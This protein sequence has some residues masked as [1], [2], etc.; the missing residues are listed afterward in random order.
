LRPIASDTEE[1]N[2]NAF[3]ISFSQKPSVSKRKARLPKNRVNIDFFKATQ[4]IV[5]S[6]ESALPYPNMGFTKKSFCEE[7]RRLDLFEILKL[8]ARAESVAAEKNVS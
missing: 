6:S 5:H 8:C 7:M 2:S 3:I 4:T 1:G